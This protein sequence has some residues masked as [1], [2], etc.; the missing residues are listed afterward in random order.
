MRAVLESPPAKDK[1]ETARAVFDSPDYH[2]TLNPK[3]K[4][5]KLDSVTYF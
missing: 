3:L 1:D 2:K 5:P 4:A